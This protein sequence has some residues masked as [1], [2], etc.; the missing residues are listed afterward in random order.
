MKTL[1]ILIALIEML[2]LGFY[3]GQTHQLKNQIKKQDS[4]ITYVLKK[5]INLQQFYGH[6]IEFNAIL[7]HAEAAVALKYQNC[8]WSDK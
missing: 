2:I 7:I 3:L 8:M 5:D 1:L 6:K 4:C